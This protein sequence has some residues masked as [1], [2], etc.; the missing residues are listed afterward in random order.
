MWKETDQHTCPSSPGPRTG[1]DHPLSPC[2]ES[3]EDRA[4]ARGSGSSHGPASPLHPLGLLPPQEG[5]RRHIKDA[6]TPQPMPPRVLWLP[7]SLLVFFYHGLLCRFFQSWELIL[8]ELFLFSW[9]A[10]VWTLSSPQQGLIPFSSLRFILFYLLFKLEHGRS[11][12]CLNRGEVQGRNTKPLTTPQIS[13]YQSWGMGHSK[14]Q[15]RP[16]G[17]W[18]SHLDSTC[19]PVWPHAGHCLCL[20]RGFFSSVTWGRTMPLATSQE[21]CKK[22]MEEKRKRDSV[23]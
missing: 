5:R 4:P 2:P 10:P 20:S 1:P 8:R 11:V 15:W 22:K 17:D 12:L 13:L 9:S 21:G 23:D 3:G 7:S 16:V 6:C 18:V 14:A 19:D